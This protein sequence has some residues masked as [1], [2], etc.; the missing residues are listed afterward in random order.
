MTE[1]ELEFPKLYKE[2]KPRI[3][4]YL[5]RMVGEYAAE[6]LT[7]DVFLKVN[8][9]LNS[10]RGDSRVSTWIYKIATNTALDRLRSS[11]YKRIVRK[12][13]VRGSSEPTDIEVESKDPLKGKKSAE[14]EAELI[15]T[16]M[17][18]CIRNF[19]D[20][21]PEDYRAV[22]L[23][24]EMEEMKNAEIADILGVTLD[25]VKIRLHRARVRLKKEL[26]THC[27]FYRDE[28]NELAC[29]LKTALK[30]I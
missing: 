26:E 1:D 9:S 8:N 25:T 7:Q 3:H 15:R 27:S 5:K 28:G 21:L 14:P 29:D 2:F 30:E 23:L 17:N 20:Q 13:S 18:N 22:I 24:S 11:S 19:V 12:A 16:E 4:R 10:F 6:D